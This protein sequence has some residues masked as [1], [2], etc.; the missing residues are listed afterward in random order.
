MQLRHSVS[1]KSRTASTNTSRSV[2]VSIR[3]PV[4]P[5]DLLRYPPAPFRCPLPQGIE[6][7]MVIAE[8]QVAAPVSRWA[9]ARGALA[10]PVLVGLVLVGLAF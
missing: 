2:D 3:E 1:H 7:R 5:L 6:W 8:D 4:M 10:L 9:L